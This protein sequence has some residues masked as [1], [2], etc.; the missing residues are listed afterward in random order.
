VSVEDY[1]IQIKARRA[2]KEKRYINIRSSDGIF[3]IFIYLGKSQDYIVTPNACTCPSYLFNVILK[4]KHKYC[5]HIIGLK[6]ALTTE[7]ITRIMLPINEIRDI[8]I[9][10]YAYGKSLKLRKL[11]SRKEND[12]E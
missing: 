8:L 6:Y 10:I 2:V 1:R 11:M 5:Y 4:K 3:S 12:F 7:Q 9:D